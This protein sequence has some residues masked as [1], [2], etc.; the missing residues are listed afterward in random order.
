MA[1]V[2]FISVPEGMEK[3]YFESVKIA[4]A[5]A[6]P[7]VVKNTRFLSRRK[8]L[9]LQGRSLLKIIA[10]YWKVLDND[11]KT[12]WKEAGEVVGLTNWQLFIH[13]SCARLKYDYDVSPDVSNLHQGYVGWIHIEN[14]DK[15]LKI[16]QLHPKTYWIQKLQAGH[17][18]FWVP[19][20][21]TEDFQLPL[22][23][24]LSYSADLEIVGENP[25]AKIYA[26]VWHSYQGVDIQ[27]ELKIDLDLQ[28]GW[29]NVEQTLSAVIGHVIHY[30]LYIHLNDLQGDLY[31]DN[32]KIEH[33]A[34]N[35]ARDSRCNDITK[36]LPRVWFLIP[37]R[38][39]G[40]IVPDNSFFK[41]TYKEFE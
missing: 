14:P 12:A 30:D 22:K 23:L 35:W 39:V 17:K 21:I 36:T 2:S 40:V 4:D 26:Q 34:Q 8:K 20:K 10:E 19:I 32:I 9:D 18:R 29:K 3:N 6:F 7:R 5:F 27:T 41:S 11:E 33:S 37:Q 25:F 1:K 38:W 15:E 28:T 24:S 16:A 13:D 31:F